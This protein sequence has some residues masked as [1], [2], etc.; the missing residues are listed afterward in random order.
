M[1]WDGKD[2]LL[3]CLASIRKLSYPEI[4]YK[5]LVVD[6]GSND[7]SQAATSKNY[8]DVYLLQNKQNAGYA[9]V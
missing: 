6:N 4:N 5:V 9:D 2:D 1:N 7:S 3:E 8:P